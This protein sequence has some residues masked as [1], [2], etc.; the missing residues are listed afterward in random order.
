[1][2]EPAIELTISSVQS[3]ASS[4]I[5]A[6]PGAI[7]LDERGHAVSIDGRAVALTPREYQLLVYFSEHAGRLLTRRHLL[8]EVWGERYSGGPRTV[9]IHVSRLR[10]KLGT[11]LPL[12]TLRS[13]GYRFG[14]S[15]LESTGSDPSR[16]FQPPGAPPAA[17]TPSTSSASSR[18]RRRSD[19]EE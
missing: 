19:G 9:D 15:S 3:S 7:V 17:V 2:A 4:E 8:Q 12:D 14:S 16:F 18:A 11:S 10:R 13:L 5:A 1:M 6:P